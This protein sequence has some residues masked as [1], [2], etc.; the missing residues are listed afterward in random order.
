M[1]QIPP[2]ITSNKDSKSIGLIQ[3]LS[4]RLGGTLSGY[5][6]GMKS[7]KIIKTQLEVFAVKYLIWLR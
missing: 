1:A 7:S 5:D 4:D 2:S 6:K 3:V